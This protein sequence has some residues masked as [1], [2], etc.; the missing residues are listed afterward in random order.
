[1]YKWACADHDSVN[2]VLYVKVILEHFPSLKKIKQLCVVSRQFNFH[3]WSAL[4]LR[5]SN[6]LNG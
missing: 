4:E 2:N 5:R 1:M 3:R 6:N